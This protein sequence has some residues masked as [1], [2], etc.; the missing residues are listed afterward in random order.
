MQAGCAALKQNKQKKHKSD[1][2]QH[3]KITPGKARELLRP[4]ITVHS[5]A[6]HSPDA[7]AAAAVRRPQ[8]APSTAV[9]AVRGADRRRFNGGGAG[10]AFTSR[11]SVR[12]ARFPFALA[13]GRDGAPFTRAAADGGRF[14][15]ALA[16]DG[17][18]R[19]G[20]EHR[21]LPM[22]TQRPEQTNGSFTAAVGANRKH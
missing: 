22:F 11:A 5:P 9:V 16:D 8:A 2:N 1:D 13:R 10:R 21:D 7:A 17:L 15:H 3:T 18:F 19:R 12:Q 6:V 4:P 20:V 14:Y